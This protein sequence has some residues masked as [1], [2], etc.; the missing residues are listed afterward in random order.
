M[1]QLL[2]QI[3]SDHC[4]SVV[5]QLHSTTQRVLLDLQQHVALCLNQCCCDHRYLCPLA[6][7]SVQE[8][9]NRFG[10]VAIPNSVFMVH[11]SPLLSLSHLFHCLVHAVGLDSWP[12]ALRCVRTVPTYVIVWEQR[13]VVTTFRLQ[14]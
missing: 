2:F 6:P 3:V 1:V 4:S 10:N 12:R 5:Q 13:V 11:S 14:S 9:D 8:L 7:N